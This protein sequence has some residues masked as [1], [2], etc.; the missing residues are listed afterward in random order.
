MVLKDLVNLNDVFGGFIGV[1]LEKFTVVIVDVLPMLGF[2]LR[3][4]TKEII[5]KHGIAA[6][7]LRR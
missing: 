3:C 2:L 1:K 4:Q 7:L 6:D 5:A